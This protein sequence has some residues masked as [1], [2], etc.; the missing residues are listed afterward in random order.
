MT[1][2]R[3]MTAP[4]S[5][6]P[7]FTVNTATV[8]LAFG[9]IGAL[10]ESSIDQSRFHGHMGARDPA[11]FIRATLV[12]ALAKRFSL[13]VL[14]VEPTAKVA[15]DGDGQPDGP[16]KAPDLVLEITPNEW[17]LVSA[18]AGGAGVAY[19]GTCDCETCGPRRSWRRPSV[20]AARSRASPW[21]SSRRTMAPG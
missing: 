15:D 14:D 19:E 21:E 16:P 11:I 8:G 4:K 20:P 18:P 3:S 13:E 10:V 12:A 6:T 1:N 5:S 17:G 2:P 7:R 9:I